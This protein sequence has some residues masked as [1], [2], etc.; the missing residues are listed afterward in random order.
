MTSRFWAAAG[1]TGAAA[2]HRP[3]LARRKA[4]NAR[5]ACHPDH[6]RIALTPRGALI[7]AGASVAASPGLG[8]ELHPVHVAPVMLCSAAG[9]A[10]QRRTQCQ[11]P[12]QQASDQTGSLQ[13]TL[14]CS[15]RQHGAGTTS[16]Q[17]ALSGGGPTPCM[18]HM[19]L[20]QRACPASPPAASAT[21][22]ASGCLHAV[23]G[24]RKFHS[25]EF[26]GRLRS[27]C[28]GCM[29]RRGD[30]PECARGLHRP[31]ASRE[32]GAAEERGG[33]RGML[34]RLRAS[35]AAQ[36][37]QKREVGGGGTLRVSPTVGGAQTGAQHSTAQHSVGAGRG[38]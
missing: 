6:P 33:K 23:H 27:N 30:R 22:S 20:R 21:P 38:T 36:P 17:Q 13:P 5:S 18:R 19:R 15:E 2:R 10:H 34:L 32:Q 24:A 14:G 26:V 1:G 11:Q 3:Q 8:G 16:K 12:S 9:R 25:R 4:S 7:E 29:R 37:G 31:A 28:V 35:A